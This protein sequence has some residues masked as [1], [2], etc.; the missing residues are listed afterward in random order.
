MMRA[1]KTT[2]EVFVYAAIIAVFWLARRSAVLKKKK[3]KI[4]VTER[5]LLK[6]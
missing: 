4:A 3:L 6:T 5:A 1:G 2:S